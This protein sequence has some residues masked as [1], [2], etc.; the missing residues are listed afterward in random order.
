MSS[1]ENLLLVYTTHQNQKEA[2]IVAERLLRDG[3][4]ACANVFP[5]GKSIYMWNGGIN[6]DEEVIAIL[7]TLPNQLRTL[8]SKYLEI[9]PYETPCFVVLPS[10]ESSEKY[11]EWAKSSIARS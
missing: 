4:I 6:R 10:S 1:T 9:H 8:E 3:L 7:K 11:L 5:A 2:E